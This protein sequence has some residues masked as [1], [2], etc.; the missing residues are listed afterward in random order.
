MEN[1]QTIR[2]FGSSDWYSW[3]Y[4]QIFSLNTGSLKIYNSTKCLDAYPRT[5]GS[6]VMVWDC[7][8]SADQQ[9][10]MDSQNRIHLKNNPD[11]CLDV[12]LAGTQAGN[13]I[14]VYPCHDGNN[15]KWNYKGLKTI[16]VEGFGGTDGGAFSQR[17]PPGRKVINI[18]GRQGVLVDQ[19]IALCD[20]GTKLGPFGGNGGSNVDGSTCSSGYHQVILNFGKVVGKIEAICSSGTGISTTIGGGGFFVGDNTV[21]QQFF[22]CPRGQVVVG[23]YGKSD[24]IVYNINFICENVDTSRKPSV[25][26]SIKP[27]SKP[28]SKP[29]TKKTRKPTLKPTMKRTAKPSSKPSRTPTSKPTL[30]PAV[31]PSSKPSPKPSLIRTRKPTLKPTIQRTA[32]PSSNP[33]TTPTSKPFVKP[34]IQ[35]SSKPSPKPSL[36]RTRKPTLKPQIKHTAKPSVLPSGKQTSKPTSTPS[37]KR[38]WKLTLTPTIKRTAKPSSKFATKST[39]KPIIELSNKPSVTP[40]LNA[41]STPSSKPIV[42]PTNKPSLKSTTKPSLHSRNVMPTA[43][44]IIFQPPV[45]SRGPSIGIG[46]VLGF[47]VGLLGLSVLTRFM[48]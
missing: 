2:M 19:I 18:S 47:I 34:V 39:S 38:T 8:G 44:P 9:W 29:S 1:G 17:C 25:K 5:S 42:K 24:Q 6:K 20:D 28:S 11:L 23:L 30:K 3:R 35:P 43:K 41:I 7:D 33:S 15:Q 4:N 46:V 48:Q 32:K 40:S 45:S 16:D 37:T 21:Q 14:V 36:I 26:P 13:D 31:K 27:T 10:Y 22:Q 12:W